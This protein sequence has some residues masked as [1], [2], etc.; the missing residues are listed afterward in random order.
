MGK[1]QETLTCQSC[2]NS[3]T[4]FS[5]RG[6]KPTLCSICAEKRDEAK[7]E[8]LRISRA[9]AAG[10]DM[11]AARLG[12]AQRR[13]ERAEREAQEQRERQVRIR[14]E[15]PSIHKRWNE[16]F[17]IAMEE[18]TPEAW[19]KAENLMTGYITAKKG[20]TTK[21]EPKIGTRVIEVPARPAIVPTTELDLMAG[22]IYG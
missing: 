2:G 14:A 1:K 6:R 11:S 12:K 10:N 16:A 20:L 17:S 19:R 21:P 5:R 15:L 22:E 9:S 4:R 13:A 18:N 8:A 3:W 7:V